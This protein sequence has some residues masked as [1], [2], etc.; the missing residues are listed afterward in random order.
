MLEVWRVTLAQL[1]GWT[2]SEVNEWAMHWATELNGDAEANPWFSHEEP[3]FYIAHLLVD[4]SVD[5]A[6]N[7]RRSSEICTA[8]RDNKT[9]DL[10]DPAF[11]WAQARIRVARCVND[12]K[13][14]P[15]KAVV[16]K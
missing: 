10:L 3:L 2:E 8:I 11:D 16:D 6:G 4:D 13:S 9:A 7:T 14:P 1:R 15:G 12:W 5:V